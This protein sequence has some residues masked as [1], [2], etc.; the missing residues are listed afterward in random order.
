MTTSVD[1][2]ENLRAQIAFIESG[3]LSSKVVD[4]KKRKHTIRQ[5]DDIL[6]ELTSVSGESQNGSTQ[7]A[8]QKIVRLVRMREQASVALRQRLVRENFS[9][10]AIDGALARAVA[11]GLVDDRRYADVLVRS[12]L[13]QGR[14]RRGIAAEL[15]SLGVDA[16]EVDAFTEQELVGDDSEEIERAVAVLERKPPRSKNRRDAAYRRLVQK[17]YSSAVASSA[18]RRWCELTVE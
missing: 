17:G 15:A 4:E 12:R 2:R 13:S 18:A 1:V 9:E 16:S 8:F 3:G 5:G 10:E 14:G 6:D 7:E 11:C